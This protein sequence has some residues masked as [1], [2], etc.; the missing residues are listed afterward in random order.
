MCLGCL[1][2]D[3]RWSGIWIFISYLCIYI[4]R[5]TLYISFTDCRTQDEWKLSFPSGIMAHILLVWVTGPPSLVRCLCEWSQECNAVIL[6]DH[7]PKNCGV[8]PLCWGKRLGLDA[9][10]TFYFF[11]GCFMQHSMKNGWDTQALLEILSTNQ[12]LFG[13]FRFCKP[14]WWQKTPL[15][16]AL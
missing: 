15:A 7:S 14:F 13:Q 8:P 1:D 10:G 6:W 4:A 3:N 16:R 9:F 12:L 11:P 5:T 2:V